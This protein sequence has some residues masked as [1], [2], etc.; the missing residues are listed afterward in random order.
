MPNDMTSNTP[1]LN[2]SDALAPEKIS[3]WL[4]YEFS[5][6]VANKTTLLARHDKFLEVTKDGIDDDVMAGHASDFAKDLR[7]E[8][9]NTDMTHTRV[10]A[11]VLVAQRLIDGQ[12]KTLTDALGLAASQV[13]VRITDYLRRKEARV[14]QEAEKEAARLAQ[15]AQDAMEIADQVNTPSAIDHAVLTVREAQ[16][17]EA[18]ALARPVELTRTRSQGGSLTALK[19]NWKWKVTDISKVPPHLLAVNETL[20]QAMMKS[21]GKNMKDLKVEGI[22]FYNDSKAYVR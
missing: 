5:G 11:P 15:E 7:T 8:S 9:S 3:A 20:L 12:R 4:D 21:A 1:V 13:T 6:H 14:R 17:A 2:L 18:R 10:K 22:E 19:D 16:Q